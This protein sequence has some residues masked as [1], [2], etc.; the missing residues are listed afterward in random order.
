MSRAPSPAGCTP[1]P[2][3]ASHRHSADGGRDGDLDAPLAGVA[4]AGHRA[5]D[6]VPGRVGDAEPPDGGGLGE[7]RRQPLERRRALHGEHGPLARRLDAADGVTHA[8]G[9]RGVGHH[10]EHV[11]AVVGP[12]VP[13]HDDVVEHRAVGVVEQVGVLRPARARSCRGRWSASAAAGRAR[14][15]RRPGPC[16]GGRRRTRRRPRG[17]RGARRSCPS[18]TRAASPTRRTAPCGPAA[19]VDARRAATAR[20]LE[21]IA[22]A[23]ANRRRRRRRRRAARAGRRCRP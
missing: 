7:H 5:R 4:G 11:V 19:A 17:R 18:G 10:V 3:T 12:R 22:S 2:T 16:R 20:A 14:S 9:V 15:A 13:P 23:R 6:A 8:V 1:A 21:L